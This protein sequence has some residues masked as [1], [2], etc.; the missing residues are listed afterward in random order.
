MVGQPSKHFLNLQ[1][2]N[3][4]ILTRAPVLLGEGISLF[5]KTT[6]DI[7]LEKAQATAFIND[8]VQEKY[9]VNYL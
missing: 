5:G 4:M 7:K 3:E 2:I 6:Q 9:V 8:F 1:L